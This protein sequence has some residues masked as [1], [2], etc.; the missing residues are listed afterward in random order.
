MRAACLLN[1]TL[2]IY[3]LHTYTH[4]SLSISLCGCAWAAIRTRW[5]LA[6]ARGSTGRERRAIRRIN[7]SCNYRPFCSNYFGNAR[8]WRAGDDLVLQ[9][10]VNSAENNI[11]ACNWKSPLGAR[12]SASHRTLQQTDSECKQTINKTPE[13]T[14]QRRLL[15]L[16]MM[17]VIFGTANI[18]I[19]SWHFLKFL[20]ARFNTATA[21]QRACFGLECIVQ[22]VFAQHVQMWL[23]C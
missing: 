14:Q 8:Q 10:T 2:S 19:L 23:L 6:A 15:A 11:A 21:A 5:I 3:I 4:T 9:I 1:A 16:L 12:S 18:A 13:I 22:K 7:N 20:T 17:A